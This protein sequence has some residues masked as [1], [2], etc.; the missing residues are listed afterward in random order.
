MAALLW[1]KL[2]SGT[3]TTTTVRLVAVVLCAAQVAR[4]PRVPYPAAALVAFP[5]AIGLVLFNGGLVSYNRWSGAEPYSV[6]R[7]FATRPPFGEELSPQVALR[8]GSPFRGYADFLVAEKGVTLTAPNELRSW[9][10]LDIRRSPSIRT[11]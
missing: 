2:A 5:V 11:S 8:P 9:H 3:A 6:Q 4:L 7:L 10:V 1:A